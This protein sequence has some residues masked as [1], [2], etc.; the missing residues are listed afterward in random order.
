MVQEVVKRWLYVGLVGWLRGMLGLR[1]HYRPQYQEYLLGPRWYVLRHLRL[2]WDGGCRSHSE[3][4]CTGPL[5][6]HHTTYDYKDKGWGVR[7]WL[8]LRTLCDRHHDEVH[9]K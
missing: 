9:G 8:S 3:T 5:Q 4:P 6:V 7:E 2:W 1:V